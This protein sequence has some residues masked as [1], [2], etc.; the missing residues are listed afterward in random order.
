MITDPDGTQ[1][2]NAS[3]SQDRAKVLDLGQMIQ[4]RLTGNG[5]LSS[6]R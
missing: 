5:Q 6:M 2:Q 1:A 3:K 4:A